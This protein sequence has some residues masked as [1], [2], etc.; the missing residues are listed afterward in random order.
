MDAGKEQRVKAVS[1]YLRTKCTSSRVREVCPHF[2]WLVDVCVRAKVNM[3]SPSRCLSEH[4][5]KKLKT[6]NKKWELDLLYYKLHISVSCF[7][8]DVPF[9]LAISLE[10]VTWRNYFKTFTARTRWGRLTDSYAINGTTLTRSCLVVLLWGRK[11]H[12][13]TT[14]K[15]RKRILKYTVRNALKEKH[16]HACW[17]MIIR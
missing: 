4:S 12:D 1:R 17:E 14:A 2:S 8:C 3:I 9:M 5:L 7:P 10:F 11:K 6:Y 13:V 15:K 16:A